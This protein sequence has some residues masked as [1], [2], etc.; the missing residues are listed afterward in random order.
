[1]LAAANDH[2]RAVIIAILDSACRPGEILSLQWREVSLTRKEIRILATKE[3]T[4]RERII[5]ISSRLMALLEMRKHDPAGKLWGPESYVFG[6]E[7]GERAKSVRTAWVN[8]CEAAGI[9]GLQ[10]RDLRHEAASRFEEAGMPIIHISNMLGHSDLSTTSRYLNLRRRG[11]HL[12]MQKY[13][14]SRRLAISLQSPSEG[15]TNPAEEPKQPS[16]HKQ[17]FS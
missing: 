1:M 2:L 9:E 11:L 13:E 8:A 12:A 14:E 3:K 7:I 10:L 6:N 17:L 4:R 15:Q 5:P 16:G